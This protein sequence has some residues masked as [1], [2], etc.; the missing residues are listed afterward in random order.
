MIDVSLLPSPPNLW[1]PPDKK[2]VSNAS[3]ER[4]TN[5]SPPP[6]FREPMVF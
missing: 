4:A 2:K 1:H 3:R 5:N 6:P